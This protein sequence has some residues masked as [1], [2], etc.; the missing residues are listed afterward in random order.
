MP[1]LSKEALS[2]Y[3]RTECKRQLRLY[4][5][6]DNA[7]YAPERAAHQM[8]PPQPPRPG[9]QHI[10]EAGETWQAEKLHDLTQTFGPDAV[11]GNAYTHS[12]GQTRYHNMPLVDALTGADPCLQAVPNSF[13]V[14]AEFR[15]QAGSTFEAAQGIS[16]YRTQFGLD[17]APLRP[18]IIEVLPPSHFARYVLP[19]GEIEHLPSND[20]RTQLRIIDIKLT[21]EPSP[22]YFA[23]VTYY[24]IMLAGW[25]I[26]QRLDQQFVV[27]PDGA[28]WPGSHDA[29][30]LTIVTR[31]LLA[32][33]ITP[34]SVQL[35]EALEED[36]ELVP[37][38]VFAFRLR[39]FLQEDLPE[40]LAAPSW[41]DLEWHV[42]NRCKGC[43]YLGYPWT[44]AQG[45][46]T[47]HPDHCI[48]MALQQ[49]HLSRVAFISRGA[50]RVLQGQGVS[51][52]SSLARHLPA[53]P[54]YDTH[55]ELRATR[56]VVSSRASALQAQLSSIPPSSGTSAVMPKWT[57]LHIYLSVD[58]DLGSAITF[59][60]GLEA[61]WVEPRF[62]GAVYTSPRM[63]RRWPAT[64][65]IVDQRSLQAEQRELLAFL[66][67]IN[68]ILAEAQQEN[69]NTTVQ[70]YLWD[71]LQYDHLTR[72]IGRHLQAILKDQSIER[73]A[74]LFPSEELLPNYAMLINKS[75]PR[76]WTI[77]KSP[78]TIVKDV[79]R[80]LL[81]A[82]VPHYYSLLAVARTYHN[83]QLPSNIAQFNIHP[84]FEDE[85]SDQVPS[86]R[87]HEI[88]SHATAPRHWQ[89]Q[90]SIL[91]ETVKRKLR[92]L[93]A[94]VEQ[95]ETDLRAELRQTAPKIHIS[96]PKWQNRLSYDSQLW[97]AFAKLNEALEEL[98]IQQI[99]AMPPHER[100]ARFHCARLTRRLTGQDEQDALARLHL[101][102]SSRYR[103]Y[104]MR[105]ESREVKVRDGEFNLALAP[106]AQPGFLDQPFLAVTQGTPLEPTTEADQHLRME[107]VTSVTVVRIDRDNRIIVLEPNRRWPGMLDGLEAQG[108]ANFTTDVVLDPVHH[109]YFTR[110]LLT[111]LQTIGNPP[112]AQ[113]NALVRQA[114]GQTTG[115]GA[116]RSSYTPPASLLWDA[117]TMYATRVTRNLAPVR[118]TLVQQGFNLNASQWRAWEEALTRQ[119]QLI[120]GPPGTG[121]SRTAR[122][123][124]I[125]AALE[126][127]LQKKPMR[128]L[129]CA[130]TYTAID[131]VLLDLYTDIQSFLPPSAFEYYRVRSYLQPANATIPCQ[132][133]LE[134]NK[135]NPSRQIIDLRSRLKQSQGI[136]I[137]GATPEQ[138]HNLLVLNNHPAQDE[139]FDLI[140]IDEASQMD[141]AHAI[142][143]LCALATEGSV[144]L[145]GDPKQLPPI[146]KAEAP[147]G[148]ENMVGSIY[149][150]CKEMHQLPHEMLNEN[151]RSNATLVEFSLNAGYQSGLSSFSPDLRLNL[152]SSFSASQPSN[153]P[154]H[155]Y[156]TPEWSALLHPDYPATCFVYPEGRSSQWNQFE[157]DAVASL[158]FLLHN[159][160]ADQ[161]LNERDPATGNLISVAN[162]VAYSPTAFWQRAVGVVTPHRAQQGLIVSRLQQIFAGT[163][164]SSSLIRDA[165]DTV[166]RFQGQQRDVMIASFALGDPDAI[167]EEDEFLMSLNRFNVMASRARAKLILFVS[168]QVVD[169]LSSDLDILRES[170][171]LKLYVD[172]FCNNARPM[173]LG[174]LLNGIGQRIGGHFKWR[175]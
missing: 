148:L 35:R 9:L 66:N 138:V 68:E 127:Y 137:I 47:N 143:A 94:V 20:G 100:E 97:Y 51:S 93:E 162:N 132:I 89:Q 152:L 10:R 34:S 87:A 19:S 111:A 144:I 50:S 44:N 80:T 67:R 116:R 39:R 79:V 70:F 17:Y 115:R 161:L 104:E 95:L 113:D 16:G 129:V 133:D 175:R 156:W 109:D 130:S 168:R 146:H 128:V 85:L 59:A 145:A 24:T 112:C 27:V 154:A 147:V 77:R 69:P 122:A 81:A 96:P 1:Y 15:I 30:R 42:D 169:H 8:P 41:R 38:E 46:S 12:S 108:L 88:W 36:L 159:Q 163:G 157:A 165:V 21:A 11:K 55:H 26:D 75:L 14:E 7:H 86:E 174:V 31:E 99:R 58:F 78:L 107:D 52:V 171:L 173:S 118:S 28:I 102:P 72:I 149:T 32:Q 76:Y 98:E 13:L 139:L 2:Q 170:R 117:A 83:P 65:F 158:L 160:M 167:Q 53:D 5:A 4:L 134:L 57:D 29:S 105:N 18:D 48:P 71:S 64:S 90:M 166:E 84:L 43:E 124:V 150:F 23:E 140:L 62:F 92:A 49:D 135:R 33:G 103:V 151:Y 63:R 123:I 119:L 114:T 82:P 74:W 155:L 141:V 73:L 106:E 56:T 6:P 164:I 25:L 110:K 3:I 126:A 121:K 172:S 125:G 153:W 54:V 101:S 91:D 22:S 131:N 37:Y 120:W 142:L 60:F 136:T 45:Q 40:V 61:I